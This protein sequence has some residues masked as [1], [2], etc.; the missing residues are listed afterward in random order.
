MHFIFLFK[1]QPQLSTYPWKIFRIPNFL[2][3][4]T[5]PVKKSRGTTVAYFLRYT[6]R[7]GIDRKHLL[8]N[9]RKFY[10]NY[11]LVWLYAVISTEKI[12]KVLKAN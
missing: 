4:F 10:F 11:E 8:A 7:T 6:G 12:S 1:S 5:G 3:I 9:P 2:N